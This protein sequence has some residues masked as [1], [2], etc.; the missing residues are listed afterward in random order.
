MFIVQ[1]TDGTFFAGET[2]DEEGH[3]SATWA[4]NKNE[5]AV[6]LFARKDAAKATADFFGGKVVK[7]A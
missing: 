3:I 4:E 2:M 5:S 1:H 7:F 6:V